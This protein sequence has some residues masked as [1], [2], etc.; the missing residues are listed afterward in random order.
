[1]HFVIAAV[2]VVL[3]VER[4]SEIRIS[5]WYGAAVPLVAPYGLTVIDMANGADVEMRLGAHEGGKVRQ[6]RASEA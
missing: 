4:K 3:P 6:D 5:S 2:K 1:M